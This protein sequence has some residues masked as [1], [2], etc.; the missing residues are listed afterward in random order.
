MYQDL[1]LHFQTKKQYICEK[2]TGQRQYS[3]ERN[4]SKIWVFVSEESKQS[5][6]LYSKGVTRFVY[7]C[8]FHSRLYNSCDE[9]VSQFFQSGEGT[10]H[11]DLFPDFRGTEESHRAPPAAAAPQVILFEIINISIMGRPGLGPN[12]ALPEGKLFTNGFT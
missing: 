7:A 11:G 12:I 2:L 1:F 4:L 9:V 3:L 5:L 10:Y 8:L 6:V